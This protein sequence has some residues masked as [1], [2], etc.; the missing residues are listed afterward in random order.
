MSTDALRRVGRIELAHYAISVLRRAILHYGMWFNEVSHQLGLEEAIQ[1]EAEVAALILPIITKRLSKVLG[2]QSENGLPLWLINMDKERLIQLID[3]MSINWLATDG[4][5]FQA[6]ENNHDIYTSKRCNDTCWTR[7]S[8]LEAT[9]IK[10]F[11]Q[12]PEQ[13]GLDG[14]EQALGLRLYERI[15]KQFIQKSDEEL[16]FHMVNCRVQDARKRKGLPDYPCKSGGLIEYQT[17]AKVIDPRIKTECI[18]CPPDDHPEAWACAW[19]F[20]I[21]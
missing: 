12:L 15:N 4:V 19:R 20:Y 5:W 7:Y 18:G 21:T 2:F 10:S 9:M 14:L 3:A 6:V 8:P 17:F 16:T 13:S 11:L 1:T